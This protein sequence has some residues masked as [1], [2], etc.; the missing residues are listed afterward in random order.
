GDA[1]S[2]CG[3]RSRSL[4]RAI[5]LP[6]ARRQPAR[7]RRRADHAMAARRSRAARDYRRERG[8]VGALSLAGRLPPRGRAALPPRIATSAERG[9]VAGVPAVVRK[10]DG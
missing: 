4:W 1:E 6:P 9:E 7:T 5:P 2:S 10:A 3:R 8:L